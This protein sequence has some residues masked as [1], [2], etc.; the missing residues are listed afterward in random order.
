MAS[1]SLNH[2]RLVHW[3][4]V[5]HLMLLDMPAF[6]T[7]SSP[8]AQVTP[9]YPG[10]FHIF[11]ATLFQP[12]SLPCF[13][14]TTPKKLWV[15]PAFSLNVPFKYHFILSLSFCS[16]VMNCPLSASQHWL[17]IRITSGAFK[18]YYTGLTPRDTDLFRLECSPGISSIFCLF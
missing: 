5:E 6:L 2:P 7:L 9:L 12:P 10:S 14:L 18:T 13:P 16:L 8:F 1:S 3:D 15:L 11:L 17:L 4:T